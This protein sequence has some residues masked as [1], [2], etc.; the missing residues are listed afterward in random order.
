MASGNS[1][2]S[3]PLDVTRPGEIEPSPYPTDYGQATPT[4]KP[5]ATRTPRPQPSVTPSVSN[6]TP[7]PTPTPSVQ[8]PKPAPTIT[9]QPLWAGTRSL[10]APIGKPTTNVYHPVKG[11]NTQPILTS[12][13]SLPKAKPWVT[14][15]K[16]T[17][18]LF[19]KGV[20]ATRGRM[21]RV[22]PGQEKPWVT[23]TDNTTTDNGYKYTPGVGN[24]PTNAKTAKN[25]R[26]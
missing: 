22:L 21:P 11:G 12:N 13:P 20:P 24:V 18:P 6:P 16:N 7:S 10:P 19:G 8:F 4:P 1:K 14:T 2:T 15:V 23:T 3:V 25:Y 9:M 17:V 5:K 26:G